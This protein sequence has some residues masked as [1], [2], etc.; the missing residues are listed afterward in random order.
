MP[1]LQSGLRTGSKR[2]DAHTWSIWAQQLAKKKN[3]EEALRMLEN[4]VSDKKVP[5]SQQLPVFNT[6]LDI[7]GHHGKFNHAW[8]LFNDVN[9]LM[10]DVSNDLDEEEIANPK[11][12]IA[13]LP[14][15]R[16]GRKQGQSRRP[17]HLGE[18]FEDF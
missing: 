15:K 10:L 9:G 11:R 17:G 1:P 14:F 6:A 16:F 2:F 3:P 18:G 8:N 12:T 13:S 7:C 5:M 4:V